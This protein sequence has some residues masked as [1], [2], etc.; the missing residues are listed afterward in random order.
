[1]YPYQCILTLIFLNVRL[2]EVLI[3]SGGKGSDILQKVTLNITDIIKCNN[4]YEHGR[5]S[6]SGI[7]SQL[8]LCAGD[9]TDVGQLKEGEEGKLSMDTCQV[10]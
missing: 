8:M 2:T 5:Q 7:V 4:S 9:T 6:P 10:C 1:M 3:I